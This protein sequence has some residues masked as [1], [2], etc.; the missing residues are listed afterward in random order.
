MHTD[1]FLNCKRVGHI[2]VAEVIAQL[3]LRPVCLCGAGNTPRRWGDFPASCSF[4]ARLTVKLQQSVWHARLQFYYVA[5]SHTVR[6]KFCN[7]PQINTTTSSTLVLVIS[8]IMYEGKIMNL[9]NLDVLSRRRAPLHA[10]RASGRR[11]IDQTF[12]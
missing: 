2:V 10:A 6:E 4:P 12:D 3:P 7:L 9:I 1:K 11:R 5:H 8:K